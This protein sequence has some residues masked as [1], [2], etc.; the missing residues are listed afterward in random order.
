MKRNFHVRFCRRG[1]VETLRGEYS[2]LP[3][4]SQ[5]KAVVTSGKKIG[6]YTGRV[7]CRATGSFDIATIGGRVSG[8]SYK[9]CSQAHQKD[10]YNYA[11]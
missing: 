11:F 8:I 1:G 3:V 5:L 6:T 4:L 7:L 9:Y 2:N 10:G